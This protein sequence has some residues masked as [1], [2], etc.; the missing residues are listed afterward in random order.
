MS[1]TYHSGLKAIKRWELSSTKYKKPERIRA[2]KEYLEGGRRN[3]RVKSRALRNCILAAAAAL[4]LF[5]SSFPPPSTLL[6]II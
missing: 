2:G 4:R 1:L 5:T 6:M 3:G